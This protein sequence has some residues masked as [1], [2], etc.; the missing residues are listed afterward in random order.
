MVSTKRVILADGSR[1]LREML[2]HVINKA[3]HLEVVQEVP[4]YAELPTAIEKFDPEWV[5]VSFPVEEDK[6]NWTNAYLQVYPS[7]RFIF[8]FPDQNHI[9]LKWQTWYE[10]VFPDVSLKD[11]IHILEK[12][13]QHT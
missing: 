7:V 10:E 9:K 1:L 11:L 4:D 6:P 13:L 8:I 5:I 2:H 3:E 12:D